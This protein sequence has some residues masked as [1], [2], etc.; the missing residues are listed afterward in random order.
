VLALLVATPAQAASAAAPPVH[1]R[2][3]IIEDART[4]EVLAASKAHARVP[5]ASITKLMTV[6]VVLE[7]EHLNDVVTIDRRAA[8]VGESSIDLH[9]GEQLTVRDLIKG[10]LIQS[11]NDAAD[12]LALSVS[13]DFGSFARLMN[14]KAAELRLRDTHFVRPDGL[15]APGNYSTAADVTALARTLMRTRF[16]R[17]TVRTRTDTIA[18]GRVVHTWDDLLGTFPH[19]LGV[20]TGHTAAAGWWAWCR[21]APP[22]CSTWTASRRSAPSRTATQGPRPEAVE[23]C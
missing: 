23:P 10:A 17:E 4:G 18:G 1:A 19:V 16:I 2:A 5:I 13:P 20:K 22:T 6:L 12:A 9:S 14:A 8:A 7:H 15:D 21:R 3:W 11:A